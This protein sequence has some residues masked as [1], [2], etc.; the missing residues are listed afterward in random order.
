MRGTTKER[1][2]CGTFVMLPALDPG[3]EEKMRNDGKPQLLK[4]VNFCGQ[5]K[6]D[7]CSR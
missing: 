6:L 7:K 1:L 4:A 5:G 2:S 3:L